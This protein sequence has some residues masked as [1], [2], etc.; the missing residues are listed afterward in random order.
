LPDRLLSGTFKSP[1]FVLAAWVARARFLERLSW[2][3]MFAARPPVA[4]SSHALSLSIR[5]RL[6]RRFPQSSPGEPFHLGVWVFFA[7]AVERW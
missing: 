6:L 7:D 2:I 5:L 1:R 3:A 4:L